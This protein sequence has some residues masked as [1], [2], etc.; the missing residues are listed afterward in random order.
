M[1]A[2]ADCPLVVNTRSGTTTADSWPDPV[3]GRD[4]VTCTNFDEWIE[5]VA[6]DRGIGAVPALAVDRAPHPDVVYRDIPGIPDSDVYLA[7]RRRPEPS[8]STLL[9]LDLTTP[10]GSARP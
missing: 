1:A 3:P 5:L 9:F 7:W 8:R 2:L 10:G 4:I 6:A